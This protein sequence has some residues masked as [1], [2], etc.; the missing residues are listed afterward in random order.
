MHLL[1]HTPTACSCLTPHF[2]PPHMPTNSA[3]LPHKPCVLQV[4]AGNLASPAR[5]PA[6]CLASFVVPTSNGN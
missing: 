3:P 2:S 4:L 6:S 1:S 5:S